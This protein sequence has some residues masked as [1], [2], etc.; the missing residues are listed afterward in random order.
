[1]I[2]TSLYVKRTVCKQQGATLIVAL[3]L[4]A[5]VTIVGVAGM[6][7]TNLEMKMI[8]SAR[9]RAI[10]FEAAEAALR[11]VEQKFFDLKDLPDLVKVTDVFSEDCVSGDQG[12]CFRGV[13]DKADPYGTCSIYNPAFKGKPFWEDETIWDNASVTEVVTVAIPDGGTKNI[14]TQYIVEFMCFALKD[15]IPSAIQDDVNNNTASPQT[16]MPMYRITAL[17]EG[18]GGRSR[19]MAQSMVKINLNEGF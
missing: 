15:E 7:G 17:A 18:L 11:S 9:D 3:V 16:H 5:I 10:A 12:Y 4:L 13:F 2:N 1:M 8:A 14:T 19:V 6:R